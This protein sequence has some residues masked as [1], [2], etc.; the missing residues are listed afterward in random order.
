VLVPATP[1]SNISFAAAHTI[2]SRVACPLVVGGAGCWSGV[3]DMSA[4]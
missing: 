2:R 1:F 3:G 4:S